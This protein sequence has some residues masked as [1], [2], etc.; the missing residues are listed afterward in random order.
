MLKSDGKKHR[1]RPQDGQKLRE[2][3]EKHHLHQ[4]GFADK[5]NAH[6]R[7]LIPFLPA[8]E[9]LSQAQVSD[10]ELEN[11]SLSILHL[12][13]ISDLFSV[14]PR[15]LLGNYLHLTAKSEINVGST[16]TSTSTSTESLNDGSFCIFPCFPSDP[17]I[18][19]GDETFQQG[20]I[21]VS[22]S[23]FPRH[24]KRAG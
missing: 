1:L 7:D 3:R 20:S 12:F 11:S 13:A 16:S 17:F 2:L 22:G 8:S 19:T 10:L 9:T 21:C 24:C 18:Q 4:S 5:V 15:Y 23:C 14:S 6:L